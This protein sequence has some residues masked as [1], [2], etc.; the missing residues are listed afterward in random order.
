MTQE[1]LRIRTLV[2]D[3][4]P[5]ARRRLLALLDDEADVEVIGEAG[6][7]VAAVQAI[8]NA[9]PDLVFLD[10]QMP[11]LDGFEVLRATSS[12]HQPFVVFVTAHDEHAIRAFDVQALDYLL[13]PVVEARFRESVR[14]AV[15]RLR[16]GSRKDFSRDIALFLDR[17]ATNPDRVARI[18]VKRDGRVNFVAVSDID[19]V[20]ADGDFVR[21]HAGKATHH[22]RETMA[23]IE[24]KLPADTFVRVHRS[25]IVDLGRIREVQPWF[26]GDYV[27]IMHD[28]T[29]LRSGRT[30]REV[31]QTLIR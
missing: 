21:I 28:G 31:V 14:R 26:K 25:V 5:L 17:V 9:R 4:E 13:K 1:L 2:V 23:Q 18:A 16:D 19:W 22:L 27:L 7:G 20:D 29:K 6:S 15:S 11:G 10:V 24:S 8:A 12:T 30:Y 3:D